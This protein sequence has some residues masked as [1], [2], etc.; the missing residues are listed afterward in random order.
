MKMRFSDAGG[1]LGLVLALS[2][3]PAS[4]STRL[5]PGDYPTI[6]AA[7]DSAAAGDIVLVAPGTY[8]GPG[9][10]NI[11][12]RGKDVV[13]KS[14]EGPAQTIIDC[15]NEGRGFDVHEWEPATTRIEGFTIRDGYVTP[16]SP[17]LGRG[18]GIFCGLASIAIVNCRFEGCE[19]SADGGGLYLIVFDGIVDRCVFS[20]NSA[21][22]GGGIFYQYGSAAITNCVIEE[23]MATGGG[24]VCIQGAAENRLYGCTIVGNGCYGAGGG[25]IRVDQHLRLERCIVWDNSKGKPPPLAA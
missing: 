3:G 11:E 23:N 18:G 21:H 10:H 20:G 1:L 12:L 6:Q 7:V 16:S 8:R 5:V 24:G 22:Y 25:G 14:S 4:A 17:N 13:V 15:E 9:N 19:A 2:W